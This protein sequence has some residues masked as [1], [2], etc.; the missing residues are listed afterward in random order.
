MLEI[1]NKLRVINKGGYFITIG[2]EY[3]VDDVYINDFC[4]VDDD[5]TI[6][7]FSVREDKKDYWKNFFELVN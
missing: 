6:N 7:Y 2:K 1:G 5:G 3:Y 4:I